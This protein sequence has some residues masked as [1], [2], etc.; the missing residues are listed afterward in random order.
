MACP[1]LAAATC[2]H[3]HN[4]HSV[5]AVAMVCLQEAGSQAG[6]RDEGAA[7]LAQQS[8]GGAQPNTGGSSQAAIGRRFEGVAQ[9]VRHRE[10]Q[11]TTVDAAGAFPSLCRARPG[12]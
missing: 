6:H 4:V 5:R 9:L 10:W 11:L 3:V 7:D 8:V 2:P 1:Y 12:W